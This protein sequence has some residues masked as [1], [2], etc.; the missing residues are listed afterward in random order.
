MIKPRRHVG[1]VEEKLYISLVSKLEENLYGQIRTLI[2]VSHGSDR[3][4]LSTTTGLDV[5][6]VSPRFFKESNTGSPAC[7]QLH[8]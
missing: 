8:H 7:S 4:W 5:L 1:G 2:T 3:G 6:A